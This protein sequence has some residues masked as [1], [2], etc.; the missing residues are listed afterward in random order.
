MATLTYYT[1]FEDL[2]TSENTKSRQQS[3]FT[4]KFDA[5]ELVDFIET[6]R[7]AIEYPNANRLL[8]GE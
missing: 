8:D 6:L 3:Y 4:P 7:S 1:S 5:N 2:K